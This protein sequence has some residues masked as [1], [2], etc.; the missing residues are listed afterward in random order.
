VA[1]RE[2]MKMLSP[3]LGD[4]DNNDPSSAIRDKCQIESIHRFLDR[5][6]SNDAFLAN[7]KGFLS[8]QSVALLVTAITPLIAG[9]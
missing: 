4:R 5:C 1:W 7:H 2:V 9:V 6:S 8:D 3:F